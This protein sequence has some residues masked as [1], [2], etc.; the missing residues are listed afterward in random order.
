MRFEKVNFEAFK[1]DMMT[2]R[3]MNYMEGHIEE[4]Y[5]NIVIPVR[6]TKYSAG[7]DICTPRSRRDGDMALADVCPFFRGNQRRS[8]TYQWY[9]GH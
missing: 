6:K 1:N 5:D 2:Y 8:G 4:A 3:P 9:R 7:Y